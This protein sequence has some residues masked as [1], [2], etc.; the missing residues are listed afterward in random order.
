MTDHKVAVLRE[1]S[2]ML[3]ATFWGTNF[4]ATKYAAEFVPPLLIVG[5]RFTV[6]G[7]LMFCLLRVLEPGDRLAPRDLL[8]MAGLGCLAVVIVQSSFTFGVSLTSASNTGHLGTGSEKPC[9]YRGI[10]LPIR[11]G[12]NRERHGVVVA[13]W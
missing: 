7:V 13:L 11:S 1:L 3:A 2:L 12:T 5:V 8:P 9:V 6:G 4:A 10:G